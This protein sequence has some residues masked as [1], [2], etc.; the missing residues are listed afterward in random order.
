MSRMFADAPGQRDARAGEQNFR[1]TPRQTIDTQ[2]ND[3]EQY[4][5]MRLSLLAV[6]LPGTI[7]SFS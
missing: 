1:I 5:A 6:A 7:A 3:P 4:D 2:V